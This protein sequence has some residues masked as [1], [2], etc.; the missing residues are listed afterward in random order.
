MLLVSCPPNDSFTKRLFYNLTYKLKNIADIF[1]IWSNILE[2][3]YCQVTWYDKNYKINTELSYRK[4]I[5]ENIQKKL[6]IIGIKDHLTSQSDNL[7]SNNMPLLIDNLISLFDIFPSKKFIIFTSLE[8]LSSY[9]K[10][11]NVEIIP[12]GGDITNQLYE[13]KKLKPV[14]DKNFDSNKTFISLNRNARN[15]RHIGLCFLY[16]LNLEEKGLISFLSDNFIEAE[17]PELENKTFLSILKKGKSKLLKIEPSIKDDFNIY[18]TT[19]N[20]NLDNF[21]NKLR[22]YYSNVFIE[23]INETSC[24]ESSFLITEKTLNSVYGCNFP[25]WISSQGT[26]SFLRSIGL[27]VFDDIIDHSYDNI[28]DGIERIYKA[29]YLNQKIIQ[30]D[31]I[32]GIWNQSKN[33][34]IKNIEF[35]KHELEDFYAKRAISMFKNIS[36]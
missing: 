26:V 18:T 35:T 9:I 24:F 28:S 2:P 33:R 5:L 31:S 13:Y 11:P 30:S 36:M 15:H 29:Y 14:L 6:I 34:F 1:Y 19:H 4:I 32:K 23:F 12:W 20:N 16:G 27:D 7:L 21:N 3:K 8:N 22:N 17:L 10:N 25:I